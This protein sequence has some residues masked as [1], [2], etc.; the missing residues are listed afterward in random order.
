VLA[1]T[2]RVLLLGDAKQ[3]K[4]AKLPGG[5]GGLNFSMDADNT[6]QQEEDED[7]FK[8]TAPVRFPEHFSNIF[9]TFLL[10]RFH[11]AFQMS[12]RGPFDV[13]DTLREYRSKQRLR[14]KM[15]GFNLDMRYITPNIIALAAPVDR[16]ILDT[17]TKNH[18]FEVN[19]FFRTHHQ[20]K[21][22]FYSLIAEH[23]KFVFD[24]HKLESAIVHDFAFLDHEVPG[25]MRMQAFCNHVKAWLSLD[26][27][28]VVAIMCTSGRNRTAVMICA[29]LLFAWPQEFQMASDAM[30][31]FSWCRMRSG[32][33]IEIPS[34][35]RYV[36]YFSQRF[37]AIPQ[38]LKMS[39]VFIPVKPLHASKVRLE[40]YQLRVTSELDRGDENEI[41]MLWTSKG[42]QVHDSILILQTNQFF[43]NTYLHLCMHYMYVF[44]HLPCENVRKCGVC[45]HKCMHKTRPTFSRMLMARKL[46]C[47]FCAAW[48]NRRRYTLCR[49]R[50]ARD[51]ETGGRYQALFLFK[52]VRQQRDF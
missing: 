10:T 47:F 17:T 25:L 21:V 27:Q 51:I 35:I 16:G 14:Y 22:K 45:L 48:K 8:S 12:V 9:R 13:F 11:F 4:M 37:A 31:Y 42:K 34:Q 46:T 19:R 23:G 20:G 6:M 52:K 43:L 33:A 2:D 18:V 38:V 24:T 3:D 15:N 30:A 32:E 44:M 36:S 41:R 5:G 28:N 7:Q 39:R 26:P 29:Y 50:L 1:G 49:Y 40:I